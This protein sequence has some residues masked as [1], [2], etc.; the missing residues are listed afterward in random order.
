MYMN[1]SR[2][3]SC[4]AVNATLENMPYCDTLRRLGCGACVLNIGAD[5]CGGGTGAFSTGRCGFRAPLSWS[6]REA[7]LYARDWTLS[8]IC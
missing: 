6:W 5:T 8:I 4:E 7:K 3:V 1:V 2:A